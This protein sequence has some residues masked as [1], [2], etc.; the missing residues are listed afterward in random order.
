MFGKENRGPPIPFSA[1]GGGEKEKEKEVLHLHHTQPA[2]R[3]ERKKAVTPVRRASSHHLVRRV[4]LRP[5]PLAL[6]SG[7][8][9]TRDRTFRGFSGG[10]V[11]VPSKRVSFE[12]ESD[13]GGGD[14]RHVSLLIPGE[15][16]RGKEV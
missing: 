3:G 16:G 9:G 12:H 5:V 14:R 7:R 13:L 15:G 2:P 10:A 11:P 6:R 1:Q 4:S 8:K